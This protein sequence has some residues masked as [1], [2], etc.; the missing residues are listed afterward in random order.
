M[1]EGG[2]AVRGRGGGDEKR[3][4]SADAPLL[5]LQVPRTRLELAQPNGHYHLKVACIPISPPGLMKKN[6]LNWCPR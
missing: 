4:A 6:S 1:N 5:C 2:G 3:G